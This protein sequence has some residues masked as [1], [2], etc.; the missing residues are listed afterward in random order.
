MMSNDGTESRPMPLDGMETR[1]PTS[2]ASIDDL[3]LVSYNVQRHLSTS[4]MRL[5]AL[6]SQLKL[7]TALTADTNALLQNIEYGMK[8]VAALGKMV[9]WAAKIA[10]AIGALYAF[11]LLIIHGTPPPKP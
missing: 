10:T 7:N 2:P 4:D 11:Y 3:R 8:V 1:D 5:S 9:Q 6:E